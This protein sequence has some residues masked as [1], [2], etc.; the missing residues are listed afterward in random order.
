MTD[1]T[2]QLLPCPFC[3]APAHGYA[4]APHS[5]STAILRLV[6]ELPDHPGSYVIE[7]QCACGSGLIGANES[8]VTARWNRRTPQQEAQERVYL[9]NTGEVRNGLEMYE[10]HDK[11][12]P[13]ADCEVLYTAPQPTPAPV[14]EREAFEA[15]IEKDGGDLG[16]FGTPPNMHYRNGAVNNAWVAWQARAA[17]AAQGGKA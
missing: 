10:R 8:E 7:G 9:V 1:H 16:T 15:W 6:P 13:L 12:V 2:P 14:S 4:I 5:H 3:G 11:F 17:I